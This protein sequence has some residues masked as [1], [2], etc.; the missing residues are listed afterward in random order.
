MREVRKKSPIPLYA[1]AVTLI[2]CSFFLR[3]FRIS[4][5]I[6]T[7]VIAVIVYA[8]FSKLFPGTVEYVEEP[9][10]T[11]DELADA[12]VARGRLAAADIRRVRLGL[13]NAEMSAKLMRLEELL[14]KITDNLVSS[15]MAARKLERFMDYYVP[16]TQKILSSY[17][18]L[19]AQG[20][21][22]ENIGSTLERIEGAL[23]MLIETYTKQLDAMFASEALDIGT[24]IDVMEAMLKSQ[25]LGK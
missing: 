11:G 25:G 7:I 3:M 24:D 6:I 23:D 14:G 12:L 5:L 1:V 8:V 21:R 20:V 10:S 13:K 16:T 15:P 18:T 19:S 9:V 2:L 4:T 22:G 17:E